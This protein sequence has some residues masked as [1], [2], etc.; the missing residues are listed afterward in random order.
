MLTYCLECKENTENLEAL[1]GKTKNYRIV[2]S[3]KCNVCGNRKSRFMNKQEAKGLLSKLGI[4]TSLR[5]I[6]VPGDLL[7]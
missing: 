1:M 7:F 4:R 2:L 5:D 6:P 3:S